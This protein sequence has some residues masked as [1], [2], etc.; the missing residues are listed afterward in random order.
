MVS[1]LKA[2]AG[3]EE[4]ELECDGAGGSAD[5][6]A[7]SRRYRAGRR[8]AACDSGAEAACQEDRRRRTRLAAAVS[9]DELARGLPAPSRGYVR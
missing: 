5:C 3:H 8:A 2:R 6:G 1:A 9:S 7:A 4:L